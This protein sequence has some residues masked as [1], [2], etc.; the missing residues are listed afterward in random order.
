MCEYSVRTCS[1]GPHACPRQCECTFAQ[2]YKKKKLP[3]CLAVKTYSAWL[4]LKSCKSQVY[5]ICH[6]VAALSVPVVAHSGH[7]LG[8]LKLFSHLMIHSGQTSTYQN[9]WLNHRASKA[10]T[11]HVLFSIKPW[12]AMPQRSLDHSLNDL[13]WPQ[14]TANEW[15]QILVQLSQ[16]LIEHWSV[17]PY[18][19]VLLSPHNA[20]LCSQQQIHH[21]KQPWIGE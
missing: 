16:V 7:C 1:A 2:V 14:L 5:M 13:I 18:W 3:N 10:I 6:G 21:R 8:S 9:I 20:L 12:P 15:P 11:N 19:H 4:G 17:M